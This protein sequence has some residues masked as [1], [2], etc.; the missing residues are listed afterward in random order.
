MVALAHLSVQQERGALVPVCIL[1]TEWM[2]GLVCGAVAKCQ[3]AY[4]LSCGRAC[5]IR[6]CLPVS[7]WGSPYSLLR[8][9]HKGW[10]DL[11]A[12]TVHFEQIYRASPGFQ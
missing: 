5:E 11:A 3:G 7:A 8:H 6:I 10:H 9:R 12:S 1:G 2:M 4:S